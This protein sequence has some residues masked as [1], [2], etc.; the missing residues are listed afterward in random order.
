LIGKRKGHKG[1]PI[2]NKLGFKKV[3]KVPI[4]PKNLFVHAAAFRRLKQSPSWQQQSCLLLLQKKGFPR[5]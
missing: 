1:N 4:P 2:S 3:V 5:I